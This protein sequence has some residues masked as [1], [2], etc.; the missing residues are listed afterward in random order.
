MVELTVSARW[1]LV[2]WQGSRISRRSCAARVGTLHLQ[3]PAHGVASVASV[4]RLGQSGHAGANLATADEI[5]RC[6][7]GIITIDRSHQ[8]DCQAG[9]VIKPS[10]IPLPGNTTAAHADLKIASRIAG[11][12]RDLAAHAAENE[13]RFTPGGDLLMNAATKE[14]MPGKA[15]GQK[16][17]TTQSGYGGYRGTRDPWHGRL[18]HAGVAHEP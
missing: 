1:L 17:K 12:H 9:A 8:S 14:F 2:N 3:S 5:E 6:H 18:A 13:S 7:G 15:G 4:A 11:R 10:A 16:P